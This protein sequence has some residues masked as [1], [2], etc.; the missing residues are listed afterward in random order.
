MALNYLNN[1]KS[2][3]SKMTN[4]NYDKLEIQ[5]YLTSTN[6]YPQLA[7]QMFKWRTRMMN[8]KM[9]F[10][11]GSIE[12][13]CPLGCTELDRQDRILYCSILKA[14]LPKLESTSIKYEDIFSKNIAKLKETAEL[15]NIAFT[16]REKLIE[17]RQ[18]LK[19]LNI[20]M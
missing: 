4:L 18:M 6:I 11:N 20:F 9:N 3:H 1:I 16:K 19:N 13:Q 5:S 15:L 17:M 8:F 7:K 2:E 14:H 12:L 10:K